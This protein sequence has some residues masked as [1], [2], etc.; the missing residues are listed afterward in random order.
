MTV[1]HLIAWIVLVT[2]GL[3]LGSFQ[4]V[5]AD[6][7]TTYTFAV[8]LE[9]DEIGHQRFSVSSDATRTTVKIDARFEVKYWFLTVYDY[10]HTNTEVWQ[11]PCLQQIRAETNDNGKNFFVNGAYTENRLTLVTHAG[12]RTVEGCV[13]TF[14][15]WDRDFL[16]SRTLL[17]SQTGEMNRVSSRRLGEEVILVRRQPTPAVHYRVETETFAIDL[18]YSPGGDWLALQSTTEDDSRLR[19]ELR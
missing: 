1:L 15:Y 3:V 19:Y 13:K 4:W 12:P 18:W 5:S 10:R 9:D 8:F 6:V 11:G 7:N 17:N 16:S 14:A 2:S